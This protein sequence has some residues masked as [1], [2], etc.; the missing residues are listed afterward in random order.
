MGTMET[1]K[2]AQTELLLMWLLTNIDKLLKYCLV[3]FEFYSHTFSDLFNL[4]VKCQH[5]QNS[6]AE[7]HHQDRC[8]GKKGLLTPA[9]PRARRGLSE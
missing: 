2:C 7:S 3:T 8:L 1:C 4:I 9:W 6:V 5:P